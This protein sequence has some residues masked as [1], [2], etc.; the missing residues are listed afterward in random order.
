MGFEREAAVEAFMRTNTLEQAAEYLLERPTASD[1]DMTENDQFLRAIEI[2]LNENST[3]NQAE[4]SNRNANLEP[5]NNRNQQLEVLINSNEIQENTSE[6]NSEVPVSSTENDQ[7]L[8]STSKSIDNQTSFIEDCEP[9]S[10]ELMNSLTNNLLSGCLKLLDTLPQTVH[11]VCDILLA[12]SLRN[13]DQW[14]K[15]MLLQLIDEIFVCINK[16]LE[17]SKPLTASDRKT[18]PDW[19]TQMNQ[20]PEASKAASRIHLFSLLFE[21]KKNE[22]AQ[23]VEESDLINN[24]IALLKAEQDIL[25][26]LN[27]SNLNKSKYQSSSALKI[28]TP[29]WLAPV[30]LLIDLYDKAAIASKRKAPLL[31]L[32]KR[33]WKYFDERN[34]KWTP[35]TSINN[36][37]I[38]EAYC[39]GEN[40]VR[41]FVGLPVD[42]DAL[43]AV[44][45]LILRITRD[46]EMAW[47]FAK[48]GV[49][50]M[51]TNEVQTSTTEQM[52]TENNESNNASN[53]IN[54]SKPV[55]SIK[56]SIETTSN[57]FW[58]KEDLLFTQS[59][60][61]RILAELVRS[62]NV[63][64]KLITEHQFTTSQSEFITEDCSAIAFILDN[65]LPNNQFIGDRDSPA[66][67]R[68]LIV[69]LASSVHCPDAQIQL[70]SE[71]KAALAR[72][73]SLNESN[74]K[75][76]RI[77]ALTGIINT[78]ID[79]YPPLQNTSSTASQNL[80]SLR[81]LS[82]GLNSIIFRKGLFIDLARV[83]HSLDLSSPHMAVTIN[84]VLKPL[85]TLSRAI[86]HNTNQM[87]LNQK[88]PK[89]SSSNQQT[90]NTL[91][92]NNQNQSTAQP[93]NTNNIETSHQ[94]NPNAEQQEE[95]V[96]RSSQQETN[97]AVQNPNPADNCSTPINQTSEDFNLLNSLLMDVNEPFD[98]QAST[99]ESENL[100]NEPSNALANVSIDTV[101]VV[102]PMIDEAI[103]TL[104]NAEEN[105]NSRDQ[106]QQDHTNGADASQP[107]VPPA[108]GTVSAVHPLLTRNSN[109]NIYP[110][111]N[112]S[113]NQF[114]TSMLPRNF[115]NSR[116]RLHRNN[117][118]PQNTL[119]GSGFNLVQSNSGG[120]GSQQNWHIPINNLHTANVHHSNPPVMLQRLLGPP[121]RQNLLQ[122]TSAIQPARIVFTSNDYQLFT[123][124][125]WNEFSDSTQLGPESNDGSMLS[126]VA[127]AITRWTEE[128]KVLDGDS[129]HDCV[130]N[131]KPDIISFW[132]KHRDEE[133]NER[134]E[135]RKELIEKDRK[136]ES[137]RPVSLSSSRR[138]AE[139]IE[140]TSNV[141]TTVSDPL[142]ELFVANSQRSQQATTTNSENVVQNEIERNDNVTNAQLSTTNNEITSSNATVAEA[143]QMEVASQANAAEVSE[144]LISNELSSN[145][146]SQQED[147][148]E[149]NCTETISEQ[150]MEIS[151]V[152]LNVQ[153]ENTVVSQNLNTVEVSTPEPNNV[154]EIP[155]QSTG[156]EFLSILRDQ[157]PS[158]PTVPS[159]SQ[160]NEESS[161]A[162]EALPENIRQEVIAEQLRLQR[163]QQQ[164]AN[165][166]PTTNQ[167]STNATSEISPEFLAALPPGIQEELIAQHN[168]EQRSAG[169]TSNPDS[170]VDPTDFIQALPLPLRRQVLADI[171]DSLL[172]LLPNH[173]VNEAQVLREELEARHRHIQERFLSSH[174]S[175][176][177]TRIL[178]SASVRG[179]L[180]GN[181]RYTI[182]TVPQG[183][184]PLPIGSVG[185]GASALNNN[186]HTVDPSNVYVNV[187]GTNNFRGSHNPCYL[188]SKLKCKQ[189]LD[190]EALSCLLI[191]L[192]V[193]EP[194]LNIGRLHRV[195]RNLCS[196]APTRQW[197]IQ[198]LLSIMEKAREEKF[199]TSS[200]D[201]VLNSSSMSNSKTKRSNTSSSI[202]SLTSSSNSQSTS[203]LSI[204]MDAALGCR[205]DV[206]QIQKSNN[207][208]KVQSYKVSINPQAARIV[209]R[210][211]LDTLISLAKTFPYQFLS[212]S[213]KE[214]NKT[215]IHS[216]SCASTS[217]S[218]K[219]EMN[220]AKLNKE[221]DFWDVL[222]KL[223]S[224]NA[225]GRSNYLGKNTKSSSKNNSVNS[226]PSSSMSGSNSSHLSSIT[227][228]QNNT[229]NQSSTL[230]QIISL[231]AHPVIKKSS[232]LT[233][234]LLRLLSLLAKT[235]QP[236]INISSNAESISNNKPKASSSSST[237]SSTPKP[238]THKGAIDEEHLKLAVDVLTSKSCSEEGLEDAT[239]LLLKLSQSDPV[240]RG[241]VLKLL[242]QGA[243]ELGQT[244]CTHIFNLSEELKKLNLNTTST[245]EADG[246]DKINKNKRVKGVFQDRFTKT[247]IL[248]NGS[249]NTKHNPSI[250]EV[251]LPS[252]AAL[253]CKTSSQS[254]FLRILKV[255]I[256]LRESI[257]ASA[258]KNK[259]TPS[260]VRKPEAS[261]EEDSKQNDNMEID[262]KDNIDSKDNKDSLSN[263]LA[264]NDLWDSLSNCLLE[265]ANAPDHHAVLV[266]QPAVEAFFFVHA[267]EK[268]QNKKTNENSNQLLENRD[269]LLAGDRDTDLQPNNAFVSNTDSSNVLMNESLAGP[270]SI[271]SQSNLNNSLS[272]DTQKFL[273]FAETH[274]VVLNQ[275]LRQSTTPLSEGP[276]SVLVD[277]TRVLDFDVK[278]HLP[279]YETYDKLK[280]M[281]L[282]AIHE[283]SEGFGFV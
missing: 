5:E 45:R 111:G 14:T 151:N 89:A 39:N 59:V 237:S 54:S 142:V 117:T 221:L 243:R 275:I 51:D 80:Q 52:Q 137:M 240:I 66:L 93:V 75:H 262:N 69:A 214:E 152:D 168:T 50:S 128:S 48:L 106:H 73:L 230:T 84:T 276:F 257:K 135:K 159:V 107:S 224:Q 108:P 180:P 24:L 273:Q 78:M 115:R 90:N 34:G 134:K 97:V 35:Y 283:C 146:V 200:I 132:E 42:V 88:K 96:Q 274:K 71:I 265:L 119:S 261:T 145:T 264:L 270:S 19:A 157:M 232:L 21:E 212:D 195:I 215:N 173:L 4:S 163:L 20:I 122:F 177:L 153:T 169:N 183:S 203:W 172:A 161:T 149:M 166:V 238:E 281:L 188:N 87:F 121:N 182:H 202:N 186:I 15:K 199:S 170:P 126:S 47:T 198:S 60:I 56:P 278:R 241:M 7:E 58:R 33:Q 171:D 226:T 271:L 193:D 3:D 250:R 114:G 233:D 26:L 156:E 139:N 92:S 141:A 55:E 175:N 225:N 67:A 44:M 120:L 154:V 179:A 191:L 229:A 219:E 95:N 57:T 266:L 155:N 125:N 9:L 43:Q 282:K 64:A 167:Q 49:D 239:S 164:R 102:E 207:L 216:Q 124:S 236:A 147:V 231:L 118:I 136:A 8:P 251:Q 113:Q 11:R 144:N 218:S 150:E 258:A 148:V 72:A 222:V 187:S 220:N 252:M 178:R 217:T 249:V 99:V 245:L 110:V 61:M 235:Y 248:I 62:Y 79:S 81:N 86:H 2:S 109:D 184:F 176:A 37:I 223:D 68:L 196:H 192:F 181:S 269:A 255:I 133:M 1:W 10:T 65:L 272:N 6:P 70:I 279:V 23:Y 208:S 234:R 206:F 189:L 76:L 160:N 277:H 18:L 22:C 242:L 41:F 267:C 77:Q 244:V 205:T 246:D 127:T 138:Q 28:L 85:E 190:N 13:G 32:P 210:H 213:I 103:N 228:F 27:D 209:C 197:I 83:S 140:N 123:T 116:Q 194:K 130:A 17:C 53:D 94:T 247:P 174:A 204:S 260:I 29:K 143:E 254:F 263:Q 91:T 201:S 104:S 227:S 280:Q 36:K 131:L 31:E 82:S 253:T 105:Y 162:N 74:E 211:V 101:S 63:V 165:I 268:D 100:N 158:V 256:Q 46:Y 16:L 38:D 40:L 98:N 185:R 112:S 30:I 259:E 12:V 25:T 129:M